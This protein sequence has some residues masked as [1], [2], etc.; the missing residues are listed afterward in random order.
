MLTRST[1][2]APRFSRTRSHARRKFC[3]SY[4][5]P[6]SECAFRTCT[7]SFTTWLVTMPSRVSSSSAASVIASATISPT[8]PTHPTAHPI[9]HFHRDPFPGTMPFES[10]PA[11]A[12]TRRSQGFCCSL[13]HQYRESLRLLARHHRRLHLAAYTS[14]YPAPSSRTVRDLPG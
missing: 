7:R 12:P 13:V 10:S 11:A 6:I 5:C 1:P 8:P 2:P 9:H 14:S 3:G 4:T